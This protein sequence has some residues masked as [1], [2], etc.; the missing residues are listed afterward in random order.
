MFSSFNNKSFILQKLLKF[1][2][3]PKITIFEGGASLRGDVLTQVATDNGKRPLFLRP[4]YPPLITDQVKNQTA[5]FL[6]TVLKSIF[7]GNQSTL[8]FASTGSL[9]IIE[10]NILNSNYRNL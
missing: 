9:P 2:K 1:K 6:G 4:P 7:K 8:R 10:G 5:P 3:Y